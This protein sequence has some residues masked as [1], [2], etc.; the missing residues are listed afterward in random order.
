MIWLRQLFS[1]CEMLVI[2][3]RG[4]SPAR[5]AAGGAVPPAPPAGALPLDPKWKICCAEKPTFM[6]L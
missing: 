1:Q 2:L 6:P 3:C 4:N 5:A